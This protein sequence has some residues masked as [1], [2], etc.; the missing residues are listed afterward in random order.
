VSGAQHVEMNFAIA[1]DA[2]TQSHNSF[3]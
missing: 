2:P 3:W 1:P